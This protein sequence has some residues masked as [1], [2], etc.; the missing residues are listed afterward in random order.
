MLIEKKGVDVWNLW[1]QGEFAK[2]FCSKLPH[3]FN[4]KQDMIRTICNHSS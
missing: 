1:K 2:H 3:V 4:Y